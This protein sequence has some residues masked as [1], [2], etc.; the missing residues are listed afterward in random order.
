MW[1]MPSGVAAGREDN[2]EGIVG[3]QKNVA[4]KQ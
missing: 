1:I 4:T 2:L 3:M